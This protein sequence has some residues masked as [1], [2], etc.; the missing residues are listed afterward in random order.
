VIP[1]IAFEARLAQEP[2]LRFGPS[3]IAVCRLRLVTSDRRMNQA[4]EWEDT[5]T[6]WIDGSCFRDTA[7]HA[8]ESLVKGDQVLVQ[9]KLKT[10]E[11][12]DRDT[13][14]NRSKIVL[15]IDE[16]GPSLRFRTLPHGTGRD[17][18]SQRPRQAQPA[19]QRADDPWGS[20]PQDEQPPF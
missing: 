8:A 11:W 15:T 19:G 2:E 6:L 18:G 14:E 7:E 10:D 5:D 17:S 13:G 12:K 9:G 3:G 20:P 16:I 1:R 4:G